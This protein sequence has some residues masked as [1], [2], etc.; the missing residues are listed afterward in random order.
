LLLVVSALVLLLSYTATPANGF[1]D[2]LL[3][4]Y[5]LFANQP[6]TLTAATTNG[7]FNLTS[8]CDPNV[9]LKYSNPW[10]ISRFNPTFLLYTSAGQI[11]GFGVRVWGSVPETLVLN[12]LWIAAADEPGAYDI[13]LR[14]RSPE[15]LCS[16]QSDN[17]NPLGDRL[18][19]NGN[20]SIPLTMS[21]AQASGW[22]MGNCLYEM[23]IHHAYDISAPGKQTWN[24][25]TLAP[26]LPMYEPSS[27]RINAILINVGNYQNTEPLGVFEG[28][29]TSGLFCKN[30]CSNSGC[31]FKGVTVW[32]TLH[33][34]FVDPSTISCNSAPCQL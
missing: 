16:G 8:Q 1:G 19:I 2:R 32:T 23:G 9:G 14:T 15:I 31:T 11:A 34:H 3:R 17:S 6:L 10:G 7:W 21:G 27:G 26:V 4:T 25:D 33:W 5:F 30:W 18:E 24:K 22:V 20:L 13:Y 12:G 29:F 28:P